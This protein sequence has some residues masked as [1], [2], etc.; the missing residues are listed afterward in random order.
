M[1]YEANGPASC[2]PH[3]QQQSRLAGMLVLAAADSF[4]MQADQWRTACFSRQSLFVGGMP[5]SYL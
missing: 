1:N 2:H 3:S 4:N 5:G